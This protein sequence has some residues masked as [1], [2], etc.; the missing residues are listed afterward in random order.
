MTGFVKGS[1]H[2]RDSGNCLKAPGTIGA[3]ATTGI[4]WAI[5]AAG[6]LGP[7]TRET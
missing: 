2:S 5:W 4:C 7:Y 6:I 1:G 3:I